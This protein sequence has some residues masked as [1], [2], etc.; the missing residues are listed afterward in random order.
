MSIKGGSQEVAAIVANMNQPDFSESFAEWL[1]TVRDFPKAFDLKYESIVSILDINTHSLFGYTGEKE[2]RVCTEY[3]KG[4][5]CK[6][7][8]TIEEF[9]ASW[10]KKLSALKFAITIYLKEPSGLTATKFFIPKG[11]SECRFTILNYISPFWSEVNGGSQEF[12]LTLNF[13]VDEP[14]FNNTNNKRNL[15]N[16]VFLKKNDEIYFIRKQDFWLA[17]RK[18]DVYT[19]ESAKLLTDPFRSLENRHMV[20][21][22]GLV[23]EYNER[24]ATVSVVNMSQVIHDYSKTT[25]CE[26]DIRVHETLVIEYKPKYSNY[27]KRHGNALNES[28]EFSVDKRE[29]KTSKKCRYT[30]KNLLISTRYIKN[31]DRFWMKLWNKVI[32]VVDYVDPI[33]AVIRTW[34]LKFAVLPCQL[35]WSNN[36]IMILP[37][38][39]ENDGKCLKFTAATEGELF[40]VIATTPSDQNTWYVL[41]ITTKGII[42]Y[43]VGKKL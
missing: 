17:K 7:G 31:L 1:K 10:H 16:E 35:K 36:L 39:E 18:G 21:I 13:E 14:I 43:R 23:L 9:D 11:S 4:K 12:H 26:F 25:D 34:D 42:F 27:F 37:R 22:F 33:Q 28:I 40:V 20:N 6:F 8:F 30:H 3:A 32:G 2:K 38:V 19:H 5:N 15:E 41:Q 24:D 29:M